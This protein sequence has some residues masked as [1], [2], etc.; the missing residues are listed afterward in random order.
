MTCIGSHSSA[1]EKSN[2][3]W[4][5]D[6]ILFPGWH[7]ALGDLVIVSS[8]D[9]ERSKLQRLSLKGAD[10]PQEGSHSVSHDVSRALS[11]FYVISL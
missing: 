2:V 5:S 4:P 6:S 3:K 7:M 10:A 9:G 1:I 8:Y 11:P